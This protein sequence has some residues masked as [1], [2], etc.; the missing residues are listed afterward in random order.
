MPNLIE[1][2]QIP[3]DL[4]INAYFSFP[5]PIVYEYLLSVSFWHEILQR[6]TKKSISAMKMPDKLHA[7][8][9]IPTLSDHS[10]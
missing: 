6:K 5:S 9:F 1:I 3:H 8:V 4:A 2:W 10:D 7:S